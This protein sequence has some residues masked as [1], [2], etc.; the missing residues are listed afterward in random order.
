MS[1]HGTLNLLLND[2]VEVSD[3]LVGYSFAWSFCLEEFFQERHNHCDILACLVELWQSGPAIDLEVANT[4]C[5]SVCLP[6]TPT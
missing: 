5:Y 1:R 4:S 6:C 3:F 2:E